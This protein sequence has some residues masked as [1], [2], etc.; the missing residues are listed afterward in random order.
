MTNVYGPFDQAEWDTLLCLRSMI[1]YESE[2]DVHGHHC[3]TDR[4]SFAEL[5]YRAA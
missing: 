4:K 1:K 2:R 3:E 5:A